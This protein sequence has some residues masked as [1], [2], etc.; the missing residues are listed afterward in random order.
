M[1]RHYFFTIK[2]CKKNDCTICRPPHCS[3]E[4]FEQ[5]YCLPDLVPGEDFHYKSFDELY[6]T[7]TSEEHKPLFKEARLQKSKVNKTKTTTS[8]TMPFCLLQIEQKMFVS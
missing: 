4:E 7:V 1:A 2:K 8:H 3:Q 6:R 5:L